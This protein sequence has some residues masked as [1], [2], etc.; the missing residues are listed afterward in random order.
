VD[1]TMLKHID[2]IRKSARERA[3]RRWQNYATEK[4]F[5][6]ARQEAAN[7]PKEPKEL[8]PADVIE[9]EKLIKEGTTKFESKFIK[10][11]RMMFDEH[12]VR[13]ELMYALSIHVRRKR[14]LMEK[15]R[16]LEVREAQRVAASQ[17]QRAPLVKKD[18]FA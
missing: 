18:L 11:I 12:K 6:A 2:D 15:L 14:L 5:K 10:E 4:A 3:Q 1:L 13:N 7:A 8:E 17:H 9:Q 16:R